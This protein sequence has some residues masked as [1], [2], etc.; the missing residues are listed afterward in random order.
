MTLPRF[1][2]PEPVPY[3]LHDAYLRRMIAAFEAWANDIAEQL[4]AA[5]EKKG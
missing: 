1:R 3:E 2:A 4:E 5:K